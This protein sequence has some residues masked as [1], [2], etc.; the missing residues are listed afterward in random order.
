MPKVSKVGKEKNI[1]ISKQQEEVAEAVEKKSKKEKKPGIEVNRD[2]CK[3][4]G[5]CVAFCPKE[6]LELDDHEKAV[7]KQ[8]E[9]CNACMLCELRCPDIAI[10][11]R[12]EVQR[13]EDTRQKTGDRRK[14]AL[15]E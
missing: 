8:P 2:F 13:E 4:C 12:S 10:E 9:K 1:E 11:V 14:A 3:G 5:I 6:V 7:V 15:T